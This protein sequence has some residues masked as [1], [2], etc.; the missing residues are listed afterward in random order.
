MTNAMRKLELRE[1]IQAAAKTVFLEKGYAE[2]KINDIAK[3]ADISPSTIY[4]YFSGKKDLFSSLN[5]QQA[6]DIRPEFE[7]KR[8]EICRTALHIFGQE[9]FERTTMDAIAVQVG[10]SKAALYQYCDSKEDLFLQVL[11]YY[12]AGGIRVPDGSRSDDDDWRAYLRVVAKGC[13]SGARK[14]DRNAFLGTVIRDSNKFPAFGAALLPVQL[15]GRPE[16]H[17]PFSH[18]PAGAGPHPPRRQP[19][20]LYGCVYGVPYVLCGHVPHH[21][22]R[23][24]RR[25]RGYL[26]QP[27]GGH[28]RPGAEGLSM[29]KKRSPPLGGDR[30]SYLRLL[31]WS[32]A[33]PQPEQSPPQAPPQ[34]PQSP[35]I[36][37]RICRTR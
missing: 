10:L 31:R 34:L 9:G 16:E 14:P 28:L 15:S 22:R 30:F 23:G 13:L 35:F 4:L 26:Y 2:T 27:D 1:R 29:I 36:W 21:R 37:R 7:R 8:E 6:A 33:E 12:V 25:G 3:A 32:Q 20:G 19:P 18:H 11:R 17:R 5:I 24:V